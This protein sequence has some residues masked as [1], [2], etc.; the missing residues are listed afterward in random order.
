MPRLSL[1]ICR[2]NEAQYQACVANLDA[3]LMS[4]C[5]RIV[6]DN[7]ENFYNIFSAYN[8]GIRRSTGDI[9]CFMHEDLLF[10]DAGWDARALAHLATDPGFGMIGVAGARSMTVLPRSWTHTYY[11]HDF[12]KAIMRPKAQ[13]GGG[14]LRIL[15]GFEDKTDQ[16]LL[17]E[18]IWFCVR[19]SVVEQH[20]L[21]FD[22]E[23]YGGF[24]RYDYDFSMQVAEHARIRLVQDIF[25]LH[26]SP[27]KRSKG[28]LEA[29]IQFQR[30]WNDKL[31]ASVTAGEPGLRVLPF[32]RADALAVVRFAVNMR[33]LDCPR[34]EISGVLDLVLRE[35]SQLPY[36][37]RLARTWLRAKGMSALSFGGKV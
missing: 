33:R 6:I 5:E 20:Q 19:R 24:H 11:P 28:W 27:G 37:L 1:I 10:P 34:D 25:P 8:E 16:V 31:P 17:V 36:E 35:R 26:D 13:G 12:A 22:E 9:L 14:K 15:E 29:C 30:K 21:R 3:T 2:H 18:G 4:E 7:R 32:S 23:T